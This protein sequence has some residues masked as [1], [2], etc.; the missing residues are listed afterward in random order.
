M[1]DVFGFVRFFVCLFVGFVF[2]VLTVWMFLVFEIFV[3]DKLI[4]VGPKDE[5]IYSG[6]SEFKRLW[7]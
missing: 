3:Q 6:V 2:G 4:V 7:D 1:I 5:V